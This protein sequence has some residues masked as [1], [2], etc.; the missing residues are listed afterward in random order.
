MQDQIYTPSIIQ[1]KLH[2]PPLPMGM[3]K[4]PRLTGWLNKHRDRPLTLVSAPAGYGK[5]TLISC[6]LETVDWPTAWVSLDEH[7]NELWGFLRYFLAAIRIAFPNAVP[8]SKAM[9][10]ATILPSILT[11][12]HKLINEIDQIEEP[13]ILVLDDYH[14]IETSAIHEL[15]NELLLHPPRSLHLVLGTRMDPPL[16]LVSLR[17]DNQMTEIRSQDLRFNQEETKCLF[18]MMIGKTIDRTK[19]I[20]INDQAEGWVTGLRLAALAVH[21]RIGLDTTKGELSVHNHYVT[22]YLVTEI[23]TKQAVA[24]SDCMLK[25]SILDR[26]CADLCEAV[27]SQGGALSGNRSSRS[28]SKISDIHGQQFLEWLQASN[29]FVIPLDG[30]HEWFRYHHI[31][32]SFLQQELARKL[33]PDEIARLHGAAGRWYAQNGWIEEAL[34]YLLTANEIQSA[35]ELVAQHRHRMMNTTQWPRLERWLSLFPPEVVENSG[36]LWI[37]KIWLLYYRAQ[38]HEIPTS[39]EYLSDILAGESNQDVVNRLAGE[40]YS[41]RSAIAYNSG[42]AEETVYSG[43]NALDLLDPELWIVRVMARM[44]LGGGLLLSGDESRAYHTF[45][46]AFEEEKVHSKRFKATLLMTACY[47]H[48]V[49]AD[50]ESM[51]HAA[52]QSIALCQ[53]SDHRQILGQANYHLGCVHYQHNHLSAAE[54]LFASVVSRPYNNYGSPYTNSVCGLAKTY[55]ALGREAEAREVIDESIAFLLGTG[56]T[57]QLL[58][59]LALQA[60]IALMQDHLPAASQ[61]ARKLDPV[62]PMI[63]M[64][65]FLAPHLTLVK[66]WLAQNTPAS[67]DQARALLSQL[68]EYLEN[69]HNTRF[70][71]ETLALRALLDQAIG[72]QPAAVESLEKALRLAQPG[73]FIRLFVD[74]GPGMVHLFAQLKVDKDL[75]TYTEQI[76]PVF[77]ESQRAV[78]SINQGELLEPLTNRELQILELLGER[79]TNKEIAAQLVVTPVTVKGHTIHIYD[80]LGVNG[81]RQAVEKAKALGILSAR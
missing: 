59:V 51:E 68:E 31:F 57:T 75:H 18:Q 8:E 32:R 27:C 35:I 64:T 25:T 28:D 7:D 33:S 17:A 73:E 16:S 14:L 22:E 52:K 12:A 67:R 70:L 15:L 81:R 6:W 38:Y 62:P 23:L 78:P 34:S 58:I 60:E 79:L 71:I 53:E 72:D 21:H 24:L 43:Q 36:E 19:L 29:L 20:E 69:I 40:I 77:P 65:W 47:F 37:I 61:W 66:V 74:L 45:Y 50:L 76:R 13:F 3:V 56:N 39:L 54:E 55:Q 11:I 46:G 42:D 4:R 5:T 49:T 41:L 10:E 80:K 1:T 26:F 9:L 44:Y 2:Q 48:W 63:P 30:N